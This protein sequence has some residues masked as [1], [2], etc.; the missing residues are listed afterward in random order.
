MSIPRSRRGRRPGHARNITRHPTD[1]VDEDQPHHGKRNAAS[2]EFASVRQRC[3]SHVA[4]NCMGGSVSSRIT[5]IAPPR[6]PSTVCA[7]RG[8]LAAQCDLHREIGDPR[9][10]DE[11]FQQYCHGTSAAPHAC[12]CSSGSRHRSRRAPRT[13]WWPLPHAGVDRQAVGTAATLVQLTRS[14]QPYRCIRQRTGAWFASNCAKSI[15]DPAPASI[16]ELDQCAVLT[17]AGDDRTFS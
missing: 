12:P 10:L 4:G 1:T 2:P 14:L 13:G 7:V 17:A 16:V 3:C 8:N 9:H 15:T 5:G 11:I 6:W